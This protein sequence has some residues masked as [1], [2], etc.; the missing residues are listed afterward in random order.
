MLVFIDESG[1]PG[2]KLGQGSSQFFTIAI[3]VFEDRED[4][5]ACDQR[6]ELLHK[7]LDWHSEFHFKRNPDHVRKAFIQAVAPYNFFY[8]GVIIKKKH[9]LNLAQQFPTR[10]SFYQYVCGLVF[11]NAKEKLLN[12]TV[13]IDTSGNQEFG[14]SLAQYLRRK[15]NT[16]DIKRIIKLKMQ[17]SHTNNLIQ[18][19]DYVAGILNRSIQNK[20]HGK[21]Y[22]KL[23]SHREFKV[24]IWP[25]VA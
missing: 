5:I 24:N 15:I 1:D 23:I 18:L 17:R 19:A 13:I 7:E 25:P 10:E 16:E 22:R 3:V 2:L 4:A 6:I 9:Q 14:M 11:E 12:A 21:I 8:Y 20:K